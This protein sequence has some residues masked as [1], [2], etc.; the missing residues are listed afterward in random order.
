MGADIRDQQ[1]T[2][3]SADILKSNYSTIVTTTGCYNEEYPIR[4]IKYLLHEWRS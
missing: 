2:L 1:K 3:E 4:Q